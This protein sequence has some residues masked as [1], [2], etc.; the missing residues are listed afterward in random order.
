M[1]MGGRSAAT[2][3]SRLRGKSVYKAVAGGKPC[4]MPPLWGVMALRSLGPCCAEITTICMVYLLSRLS[5]SI[6]SWRA[7]PAFCDCSKSCACLPPSK[8]NRAS[9]PHS[10]LGSPMLHLTLLQLRCIIA[11]RCGEA[12][13]PSCWGPVETAMICF[14]RRRRL[15]ETKYKNGSA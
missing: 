13:P 4:A 14:V 7:S 1:A 15:S 5:S 12:M 6:Q 10:R 2:L 9:A 8:P 3:S 11:W